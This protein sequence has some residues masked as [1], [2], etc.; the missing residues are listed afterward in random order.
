MILLGL[1]C[2]FGCTDCAELKWE[3]IDFDHARIRFARTKT[4]VNRNLPL[5]QE[6]I[7]ALRKLPVRG[8]FVF[9]TKQGHK[10][11]RFVRKEGGGGA[12][13]MLN[14]NIVSKEFSQLLRS[15]G[16]QTEKGV[17]F[18]TL[19]RTAAT[20]AARSG[21]PF[22]VQR[23]LGHADFKMASVY[24]QDV[25]EQTDRVVGNVRKLIIQDG[26]LRAADAGVDA[27]AGI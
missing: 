21:D 13:K 23:L 22:A 7:D 3:N 16:I 1:N 11:V 17:G 9:L 26:S 8:D 10:Y 5:W 18:Y 25:S 2:G 15:C 4:G 12:V 6:T 27:G 24:V 14:Y 20:L 19:R